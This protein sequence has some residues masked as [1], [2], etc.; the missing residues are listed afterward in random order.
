MCGTASQSGLAA[1][2]QE[3]HKH[4]ES[5][6]KAYEGGI[7]Q[8]LELQNATPRSGSSGSESESESSSESEEEDDHDDGGGVGLTMDMCAHERVYIDKGC[9]K[10]FQFQWWRLMKVC[11]LPSPDLRHHEINGTFQRC[12]VEPPE[13]MYLNNLIAVGADEAV[14]AKQRMS[15]VDVWSAEIHHPHQVV[16][17][18][19]FV[20]LLVRVAHGRYPEV[21]SIAMR[22]RIMMDRDVEPRWLGGLDV[23]GMDA[24]V[25][26]QNTIYDQFYN[27]AIAQ[28]QNPEDAMETAD[29]DM[30]T[31]GGGASV[32]AGGEGGDNPKPKG[33]KKGKGGAVAEVDKVQLLYWRS[34]VQEW[35]ADRSVRMWKVFHFMVMPSGMS[36]EDPGALLSFNLLLK[37]LIWCELLDP[38]LTVKRSAN[39]VKLTTFDP[40]VAPQHHPSNDEVLLTYDEFEEAMVRFA[41]IKTKGTVPD[42]EFIEVA[43]VPFIEELFTQIAFKMPGRF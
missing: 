41:K 23:R 38:E 43:M 18:Y 27:E 2:L 31:K 16:N 35:I 11:R 20:E 21:S 19:D 4:C 17:L 22:I 26:L 36:R 3:H 7:E 10:M 12:Q 29:A 15:P 24:M 6:V 1:A 30:L 5:T 42:D 37:N 33:K 8:L 28:G 40:D 34:D 9:P 39:A 32:A 25:D 13:P 14:K